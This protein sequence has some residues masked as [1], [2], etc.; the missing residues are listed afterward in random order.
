MTCTYK[1]ASVAVQGGN[2]RL[3]RNRTPSDTGVKQAEQWDCETIVSTYTNLDNHPSVLGTGRKPKPRRP[4]RAPAAAGSASA[5]DGDGENASPVQQVT[6][7]EKTGLPVGVLPERSFN[8][9]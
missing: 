7:S 3:T 1:C 4:R 9:A 8:D 2:P 6:L 5:E